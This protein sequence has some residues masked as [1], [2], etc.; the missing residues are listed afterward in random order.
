MWLMT[1]VALVSGLDR[2]TPEPTV[3]DASRQLE[4]EGGLQPGRKGV[5][6]F[7]AR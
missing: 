3:N 4:K 7:E 5:R 6:A 1:F 2:P